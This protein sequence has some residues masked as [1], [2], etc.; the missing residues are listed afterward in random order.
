MSESSRTAEGEDRES[1]APNARAEVRSAIISGAEI[2]GQAVWLMSLSP[3]HQHLQLSDIQWALL[4]S[5]SLQQFK[6]FRKEGMPAAFVTWALL[7]DAVQA[8][9]RT[10]QYRLKPPDWNSGRFLWLIDIVVPFGAL[11]AVLERVRHDIFP[12]QEFRALRIAADVQVDTWNS[13]EAE[14]PPGTS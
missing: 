5:I 11:D 10:G 4:P 3:A 6:L 2:I 14:R 8:K 12:D 1:V 13:T 9:Y 7:S